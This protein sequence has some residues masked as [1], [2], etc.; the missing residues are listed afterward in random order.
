MVTHLSTE[1]TTMLKNILFYI[2]IYL[3]YCTIQCCKE[4]L[5]QLCWHFVFC[6]LLQD[7]QEEWMDPD[8]LLSLPWI[9]RWS[10]FWVIW[11]GLDS[12]VDPELTLRSLTPMKTWS[13]TSS[14]RCCWWWWLSSPCHI[15]S[16]TDSCVTFSFNWWSVCWVWACTEHVLARVT[17]GAVRVVSDRPSTSGH[18]AQPGQGWNAM[19]LEKVSSSRYRS[20]VHTGLVVCLP[21]VGI[22]EVDKNKQPQLAKTG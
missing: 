9:C 5:Q 17:R 15:F 20:I 11:L 14:W 16:L 2:F 10:I 6:Q 3:P 21:H 12:V 1:V 13:R 7:V 4:S 19:L 18:E 22:I 8:S